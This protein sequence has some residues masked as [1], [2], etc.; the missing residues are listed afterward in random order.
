[1]SYGVLINSYLSQA[2]AASAEYTMGAESALSE[3]RSFV[4]AKELNKIRSE[5]LQDNTK[6]FLEHQY[7]QAA[8]E[9]TICA[10]FAKHHGSNFKYE[11]KTNPPKDVD[12]AFED[13]GFQYNIEIKCADYSV[14]HHLHETEGIFLNSLGRHPNYKEVQD[15]LNKAF[16]TSP[17]VIRLQAEQHMDNKL[18]DF[19]LS[20]HEKF[21]P[22]N[23]ENHINILFVCCNHPLDMQKWFGYLYENQGLFRHDSFHPPANYNHVDAVVLS[24]VYH[25]H[26]N[27]ITK[28]KV[29]NHWVLDEAFNIICS[30]PRRAKV[31]ELG[32]KRFID[33]M[34]NYS[35]R[36]NSYEPPHDSE[37]ILHN[38]LR[39][40]LFVADVLQ[41]QGIHC[42]QPYP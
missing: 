4:S 21:T 32:L 29:K 18:K 9:L 26:Y 3:L 34:P 41:A 16:A 5:K 15:D 37:G 17:K 35:T 33:L 42:F 30:N 28:D 6:R 31:K 10:H 23:P 13:S 2:S 20:A 14:S 8:C 1:L 19:L 27:Y 11:H 40:P 38:S 36:L 7:L 39:I 22:T 12:C 25:R 24:N